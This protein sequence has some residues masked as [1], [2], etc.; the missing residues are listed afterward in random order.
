MWAIFIASCN[1][2]WHFGLARHL[3]MTKYLKYKPAWIQLLIFGSLTFGIYLTVGLLAVPLIAW[4]FNIPVQQL[5]IMNYA[6]ARVMAALKAL[7]GLLAVIFFL[8]P[9]LV[10]AYLSDKR[11]LN[12][13]GWRKPMPKIFWLLGAILMLMAFPFAS[14]LNQLNQHL[15][16][17]ASMKATEDALRAM[18]S[19]QNDF[20]AAMLDMKNRWDL[21]VTLIV[22]AL[23]PAICEEFFFRGV[24]QRLFIQIA[25]RPWIGIIITGILFSAFH[26]QFWSFLP[27][28]LLGILLGAIYWYSG[29]IWPAVLAHFANNAIQVIYVFK[30][31]SFIDKE[32]QI[33]PLVTIISA[34]SI[35]VI[36]WYMRRISHT[37]YGELYDTDDELIL[38]KRDA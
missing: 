34:V 2:G 11:M 27:K 21:L 31:K 36:I 38:P 15:H 14:W 13:I 20:T 3:N 32:P 25:Q 19:E 8:L 24:L 4:I 17:P 29:S 33:Q 1:P 26:G 37:H 30:D 18:E 16:F 5:Q 23:F 28:A 12:Y 22:V 6:D 10:F 9:A 35:I 7:Q